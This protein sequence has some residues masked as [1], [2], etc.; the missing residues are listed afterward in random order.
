VKANRPGGSFAK[1]HFDKLALVGAL[2]VLLSSAVVLVLQVASR[3]AVLDSGASVASV[4]G[5]AA[6]ALDISNQMQRVEQLRNPFAVPQA[7]QRMFVGELRVS[8]VKCAKPISF[9]AMTCPFCSEAQPEGPSIDRDSDGDGIPD[10]IER[11]LG[12]NPADPSDAYA[13]PDGDRFNNLLEY[14]HGSSHTNAAS[15]PPLHTMLRLL[16]LQVEVFNM[17][18]V[19]IVK[20]ATGVD[21]FQLNMRDLRRTH[22]KKIG[23][24]AEGWTLDSY[25]AADPEG[26]TLL[27]KRGDTVKRLVQGKVV[28][29]ES[30]TALV[31][32]LLDPSKPP[33]QLKKEE[34]FK[35][36]GKAYKVVDISETR[37]VIRDQSTESEISV[38]LITAEDRRFIQGGGAA[39]L[40]LPLEPPLRP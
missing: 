23:E 9:E 16:R 3:K 27:L 2:A 21:V 15:M 19:S 18:F 32:N 20:G 39:S 12:L 7:S 35:L 24:T 26:P 29:E 13:D 36:G 8:C 6:T 22:L 17:R 28:P 30:R 34:V 1:R 37:V 11:E 31:V 10:A 38:G 14:R 25:N 5:I 33:L 40:P 4:D